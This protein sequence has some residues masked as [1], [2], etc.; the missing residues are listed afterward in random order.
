MSSDQAAMLLVAS[1]AAAEL[2]EKLERAGKHDAA[3]DIDRLAA[4]L[5]AEAEEMDPN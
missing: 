1:L 5:M 2:A 4:D 3:A